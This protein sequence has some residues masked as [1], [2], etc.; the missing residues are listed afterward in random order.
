MQ[1]I[2]SL[3]NSILLRE[4]IFLEAKKQEGLKDTCLSL[5][6]PKRWLKNVRRNSTDI[7]C[8]IN[9]SN[10]N[11]STDLLSLWLLSLKYLPMVELLLLGNKFSKNNSNKIR[12]KRRKLKS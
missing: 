10:V 12:P 3:T 9:K 8:L 11:W 5:L 6:S 2:N 7:L 4:L 1:P